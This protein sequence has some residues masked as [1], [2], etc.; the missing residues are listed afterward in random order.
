MHSNIIGFPNNWDASPTRI[1]RVSASASRHTF[2]AMV[3]V[4]RLYM[5]M[6]QFV[7]QL[8]A[9]SNFFKGAQGRQDFPAVMVVESMSSNL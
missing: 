4:T 8:G 7:M 3:S 9:E 2:G 5:A 1:Y 6:G